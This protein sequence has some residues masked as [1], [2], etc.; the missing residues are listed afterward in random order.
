MNQI[1]KLTTFYRLLCEEKSIVI[2]KVQRD[3]AYGRQDNR[4]RDILYGILDKIRNA[5]SEGTHEVLDFVY[6]A[7]Y[8]STS[9]SHTGMIPL[10]GQQRLT[11]LFLLHFYGSLSQL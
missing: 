1:G 4:T 7:S 6:G 11:V 8:A 2:P 5:V 3:F 9:D 10:D